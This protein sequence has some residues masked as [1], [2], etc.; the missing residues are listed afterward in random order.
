MRRALIAAA[1]YNMAWGALIVAVPD[2]LFGWFEMPP[3]S[4]AGLWQCVGVIVGVY[5]VGYVA[6]SRDPIGHWPITLVGLLG[7]LLAPAAFVA[8]ALRG[9]LS[10]RFGA[11][12]LTTGMLWW[13]PFTVI[14]VTA[15]R[16]HS[17]H[18]PPATASADRVPSRKR[19]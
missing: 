18:T 7:K 2:T 10:W 16:A 5:G 11:T 9:E 4:Y 14:L 17:H 8:A 15:W 6:A 19:A 1:A 12:L 3:P 13:V